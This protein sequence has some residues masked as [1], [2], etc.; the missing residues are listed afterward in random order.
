MRFV[1]E[2][3]ARPARRDGPRSDRRAAAALVRKFMMALLPIG[4]AVSPASGLAP[5]PDAATRVEVSPGRTLQVTCTGTGDRTVVLDA[6]GSDWSSIWALIQPAIAKRA[7]VCA[8]DRAGLGESDPAAEPRSP[9]AVVEDLRA[10]LKHLSPTRPVVLVGHS[11]GGFNMKLYAAIYPADVAGLVLLDPSEERTWDRTRDA[12]VRKYGSALAARSEL[13]DRRFLERL[14]AKFRDC[15]AEAR[16]NGLTQD[17]PAFRRCTDP[18]RPA[19]GASL[20]AER[21]RIMAGAGYQA[22]QAS[23]LAS[24]VYGSAADDAVYAHLFRAGM[25]G[26]RPMIVLNHVEDPS[27][28]PLD[29][30]GTEQGIMLARETARLSKA[31]EHR[32]VSKSG[33]Y[34][35]LDRPDAVIGAIEEVLRKAAAT[36]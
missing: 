19:I 15:A 16:A 18:P 31:G 21:K 17:T 8:Y 3:R 5:G 32:L 24:S 14:V 28:D 35:Q 26:Q 4:L 30:L 33:H 36:K 9:I 13:L 25:F 1:P 12:I 2:G 20:E 10:L 6:G 11:L 7:R 27:D 23:E 29:R 22:T 34:L